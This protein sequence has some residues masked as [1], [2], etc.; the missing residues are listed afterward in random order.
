MGEQPVVLINTPKYLQVV[1]FTVLMATTVKTVLT[2]TAEAAAVMEAEV[3][4]VAM[5]AMVPTGATA[6]VGVKGVLVKT[7]LPANP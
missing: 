2:A 4:L 6:T 1:K 3:D 5:V 7:V